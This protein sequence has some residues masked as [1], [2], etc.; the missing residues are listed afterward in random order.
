[1]DY[2]HTGGL[3]SH[4]QDR[5]RRMIVYPLSKRERLMLTVIWGVVL[6]A[7][8]TVYYF[9]GVMLFAN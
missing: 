8:G 1:M 2:R 7:C 5:V 9:M 4:H 6:I 3:R